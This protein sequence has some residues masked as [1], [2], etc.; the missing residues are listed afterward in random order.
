MGNQDAAE[1][2]SPRARA[3]FSYLFY[4]FATYEIGPPINDLL[5]GDGKEDNLNYEKGVDLGGVAEAKQANGNIQ[6][7]ASSATN[8]S[9]K[10]CE[11]IPQGATTLPFSP[12]ANIR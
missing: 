4:R 1:E 9:T 10:A 11:G 8:E 6:S 12:T 2:L 3:T 7:P 5:R